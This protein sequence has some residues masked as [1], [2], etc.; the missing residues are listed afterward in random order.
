MQHFETLWRFNTKRFSVDLAC[1]EE[2]APDISWDESGEVREKLESGEYVCACFRIRVLLDGAE[3]AS[4][5]LGE[6]IYADVSDFRREHIGLTAKSR[7]DGCNYGDYF[8]GMV[9]GAIS[10]ARK[11]LKNPPRLRV[12]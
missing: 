4:D 11:H 3:I 2:Y 1:A 5:Y 7:A 8:S 6:S 12:A 10:A 9:R